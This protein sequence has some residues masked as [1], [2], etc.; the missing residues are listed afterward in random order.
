VDPA[1]LER[2]RKMSPEQRKRLQERLERY[3]KLSEDERE[4][5]RLNLK[6]FRTLPPEVQKKL[7][8]KS[9]N[10]S[11]ADRKSYQ[12]LASG[13]FRAIARSDRRALQ[14]FPR[15]VFFVWLD[16]KESGAKERLQALP[17]E[18]R[19]REFRRLSEEFRQTVQ[20]RVTHHAQKHRCSLPE[21]VEDLR[22]LPPGEYWIRWREMTK[23][24]AR[25]S[26]S[27]QKG[28]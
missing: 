23:N 20:K 27:L 15:V 6:K 11:E 13:F 3:R 18:E 12:E 16:Q 10:L 1:K 4:R 22:G 25:Q 5:L 9:K 21:E 24:C 28:R 7:R 17:E 8:E 14:A 26:K 19:I 2:I